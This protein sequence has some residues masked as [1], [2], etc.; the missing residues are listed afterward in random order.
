MIP[1][2]VNTET[3]QLEAV[4]VGIANDMGPHHGNNPD[5]QPQY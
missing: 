3:S 1:L 4:V 2:R 5:G